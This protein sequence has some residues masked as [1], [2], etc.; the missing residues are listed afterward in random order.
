MVNVWRPCLEQLSVVDSQDGKYLSWCLI[1]CVGCNKDSLLSED[2][3]DSPVGIHDSGTLEPSEIPSHFKESFHIL[4]KIH[5]VC[6]CLSILRSL[7]S[8]FG[9][10]LH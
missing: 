3:W 2:C 4:K 5:V 8:Y 7:M 9:N 10:L 6:L 1:S